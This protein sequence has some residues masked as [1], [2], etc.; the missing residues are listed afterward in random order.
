M[1]QRGGDDET[2]ELDETNLSENLTVSETKSELTDEKQRGQTLFNTPP[3][4]I[5]Q[6]ELSR[7]IGAGGFGIVYEAID[8]VLQRTVAI[9][10]PREL[11]DNDAKAAF[12]MEARAVANLEHVNIVP[13]YEA[14]EIDGQCYLASAYC[15]GGNLAALIESNTVFSWRV[16]AE[17]MERMALAMSHAHHRGV[18]HR[19]LKPANVVLAQPMD[20]NDQDVVP[21][22]RITDFGLARIAEMQ[23]SQSESSVLV[24]TPCYMA[25]E[26]LT[27]EGHSQPELADIY[28][29]GVILYQLLTGQKPYDAKSFVGVVDQIRNCEPIAPSLIRDDVPNDL[30]TIALKCMNENPDSRYADCQSLADDLRSF[31]NGKSI[32]SRPPSVAQHMLRWLRSPKRMVEAGTFSIFVGVATPLWIFTIVAFIIAEDLE[33]DIGAEMIPQTLLVCFGLLVPLVY[34]GYQTRIGNTKWL[35]PG[36]VFSLFSLC[37]V[38]PPLF[39]NIYV[40]PKLYE[41]YPLGRIIAYSLLTIEHLV[42]VVQYGILVFIKRDHF[43]RRGKTG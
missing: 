17:M 37:L 2:A 43:S 14:G 19:D 36:L 10:I 35:V 23:Q 32:R 42:Q 29:L 38:A 22:L 15:G 20:P 21:E 8:T 31:I 13:V 6:F 18:V 25:P 1:S 4:I 39:G 40:F 41:R 26:Q 7:V 24:G 28:S 3:E 5:G 11:P 9:K 16:I 12:L 34:I 27:D 30:E 33:A